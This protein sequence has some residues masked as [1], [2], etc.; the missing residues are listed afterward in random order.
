MVFFSQYIFFSFLASQFLPHSSG[1]SS[2]G[3]SL[4]RSFYPF[5]KDDTLFSEAN[6]NPVLQHSYGCIVYIDLSQYIHLENMNSKP[7]FLS[8]LEFPDLPTV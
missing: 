5:Y 1:S 8:V 4:E 2:S 3:T 7:L 6:N